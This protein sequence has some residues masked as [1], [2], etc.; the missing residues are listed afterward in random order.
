VLVNPYDGRTSRPIVAAANKRARQEAFPFDAHPRSRQILIRRG[1]VIAQEFEHR[2]GIGG[3]VEQGMQTRLCAF[4]FRPRG[5]ENMIGETI[6]PGREYTA[7]ARNA[8]VNGQARSVGKNQ[9]ESIVLGA[10][11]FKA[12][13]IVF[14]RPERFEGACDQLPAARYIGAPVLRGPVVRQC[15]EA[16]RAGDS[17]PRAACDKIAPRE[18]LRP[19]VPPMRGLG[20]TAVKLIAIRRD[21]ARIPRMLPPDDENQ[22]HPFILCATG[23]QCRDYSRCK[24]PSNAPHLPLSAADF[25]RI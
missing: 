11:P 20:G 19:V 23:A 10:C 6:N 14:G 2:R 3:L 4:N 15:G 8:F 25:E 16:S 18:D 21:Q 22:A 1:P 17:E 24:I 12:A 9:V 7:D 5:I 13:Q